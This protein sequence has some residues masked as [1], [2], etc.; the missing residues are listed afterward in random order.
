MRSFTLQ[1]L[2]ISEA[3]KQHVHDW[4]TNMSVADFC[5]VMG[6]EVNA[7]ME[8]LLDLYA[9]GNHVDVNVVRQRATPKLTPGAY[10]SLVAD[11]NI[12]AGDLVG[13]NPQTP[14]GVAVSN[15]HP[16]GTVE[17]QLQSTVKI[18]LG[19]PGAKSAQQYTEDEEQARIRRMLLTAG[20]FSSKKD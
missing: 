19:D 1:L 8:G 10:T 9:S 18:P 15:P 20:D 7:A 6:V 11:R 12:R 13:V 4:F 17:V 5:R 14:L 3:Y 16:D 2:G